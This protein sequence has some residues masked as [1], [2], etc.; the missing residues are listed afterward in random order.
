MPVARVRKGSEPV[1][2]CRST[3]EATPLRRRLTAIDAGS[4]LPTAR[5]RRLAVFR[6]QFDDGRLA[7]SP[8]GRMASP[9]APRV[10]AMRSPGKARRFRHD[11]EVG[12]G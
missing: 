10:A 2:S 12:R 9:P 8:G 6:S 7:L 3:I 4:V 11:A 5:L 1:Q